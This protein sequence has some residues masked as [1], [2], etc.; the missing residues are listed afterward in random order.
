MTAPPVL[1]TALTEALGRLLPG[2]RP[3]DVE[4][5][6][7]EE[8]LGATAKAM[9]YGRPL[10]VSLADAAGT[11]RTV[12]FRTARADEFG[13]DRRSDRAGSLLLDFDLF[14][15]IPRHVEAIDVGAID[16]SGD[17]V[18]LREAG[19]FYLITEYVPGAPYAEDLRR[20]ARAGAAEGDVARSRELA[21][22]LARLH[23]EPLEDPILYRRAVRDLLGHGEGIFGIV[24][25]Y[26]RDTP[27]APPERLEGI[28]RRCLEWRWRLKG[29]E[30]RLR[31]VHGD[32]HPFNIV[33]GEGLDFT[34]LDAS[35]GCA[36]DPAD[37]FFSLAIN[38][39]FFA[40]DAPRGWRGGLRD[41][42][43]SFT[44]EYLARARDA[45]ILEVGAPWLAWRVLVVASPRWYPNLPP[46]ARD[47]LLGLAERVL[48]A[49]RIE[50]DWADRLF[51]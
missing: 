44:E 42:W 32:F 51:P 38:Y 27:E 40:I 45:E 39:P 23:A 22:Y 17:L 21:R 29:R 35:R 10:K 47:R 6:G 12:V 49:P 11:R 16:R 18:S 46:E 1:P 30:R 26:P 31:R 48:D 9:G 19:E 25:A 37:D 14:G 36:G 34:L 4:S 13:H 3:V 43:R 33:F 50:P 5:L 15:R 7:G 8:G 24:D 2:W 41:L 20:V 28:E